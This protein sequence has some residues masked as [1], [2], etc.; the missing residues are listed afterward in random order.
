MIVLNTVIF[1]ETAYTVT[2]GVD[3]FVDIIILTKNIKNIVVVNV[4][5]IPD[6]AKG[7]NYISLKYDFFNVAIDPK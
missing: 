3:E 6:S 5:L 4:S 7:L 1:E 2:E